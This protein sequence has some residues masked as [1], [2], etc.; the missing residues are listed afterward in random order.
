MEEKENFKIVAYDNRFN[1]LNFSILNKNELNVLSYFLH[2][3]KDKGQSEVILPL[4]EIKKYA[5]IK[6]KN[7]KILKKLLDD[8]YNKII[9]MKIPVEFEKDGQKFKGKFN[10]FRGYAVTDDD[11]SFFIKIEDQFEFLINELVDKFT[12]YNLED[13]TSLDSTYS[14]LLFQLLKQ[15]D[16]IGKYEIEMSEFREKLGIPDS[17]RMSEI[18]KRVLKPINDEL[19]KFFK[20]FSVEKKKTGKAVS[21][22]IFTWVSRKKIEDEEKGIIPGR[23]VLSKELLTEVEKC[24][25]NRYVSETNV[26]TKDNLIELLKEFDEK[27]IIEALKKIY[28]TANKPITELNYFKKVIH[29]LKEKGIKSE[30]QTIEIKEEK[31]KSENEIQKEFVKIKVTQAEY[32]KIK[33]NGYQEY[34]DKN[35]I[36][37]DS[38]FYQKGYEKMLQEKYEILIDEN[39]INVNDKEVEKV[40]REI[41]ALEK[42]LILRRKISETIPDKNSVKYLEN[43]LQIVETE[44]EI[45]TL[46]IKMDS[47]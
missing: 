41:E 11:Q 1:R 42:K 36:E 16:G 29:D 24:K 40:S 31:I 39:Q 13:F 27:Y 32:E 7:N 34:L 3:L 47:L 26:L 17:Y 14:Q 9:S 30:N 28:K 6:H 15:W 4:T 37:E 44:I 8:M 12:Q 19:P 25:R 22:F 2:A 45:E 33:K 20:K 18:N 38:I 10:L 35:N 23:L 5:N 46:K 21:K 43:E